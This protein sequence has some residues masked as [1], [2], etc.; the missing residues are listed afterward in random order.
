MDLNRLALRATIFKVLRD[1][2]DNAYDTARAEAAEELGPEGRKN[3][4][5]NGAKLA[6]V[7]VPKTGRFSVSSEVLLLNWVK[8]YYPTEI[9]LKESVRPAFLTLLRQCTQEAGQP[10]GPNGELDVPGISLGDPYVMVRPVEGADVL[11]ADLWRSGRI[12]I[13]TGTIK[14]IEA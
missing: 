2:V 13:E 10:M 3:A 8:K 12:D 9:E 5:Y 6:S 11:I 7:S 4:L 1:R 14:E